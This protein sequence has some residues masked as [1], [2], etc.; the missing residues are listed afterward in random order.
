MKTI[1]EALDSVQHV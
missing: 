1:N